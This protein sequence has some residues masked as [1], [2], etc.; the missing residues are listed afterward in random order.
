MKNNIFIRF[1]ESPHYISEDDILSNADCILQEVGL[2]EIELSILFCNGETIRS[3]NAQYRNKD[4][5]TD[6]LSFSQQEGMSEGFNENILGD[7]V[8]CSER[9]K[10]QAEDQNVSILE[11]IRRLMIHGI[12]H[13]LGYEHENGGEEADI[14]QKE[15]LKLMLTVEETFDR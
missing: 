12:L 3:L 7:L 11:E 6:V 15:E 5:V 14:M 2:H 8:I 1:E 10:Q 9:A 4:S 13:L